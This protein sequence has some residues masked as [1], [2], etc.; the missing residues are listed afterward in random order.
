MASQTYFVSLI[1][2]LLDGFQK[3]VVR[4]ER[5]TI[6]LAFPGSKEETVPVGFG[7]DLQ[8]IYDMG[9]KLVEGEFGG[10]ESAGTN[11]SSS[12]STLP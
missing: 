11:Q 6:D 5:V 1:L 3:T 8:A 9:H 2:L 4:A 7:T 10:S 12:D